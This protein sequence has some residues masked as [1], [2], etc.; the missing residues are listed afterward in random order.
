LVEMMAGFYR[1]VKLGSLT[2]IIDIENPPFSQEKDNFLFGFPLGHNREHLT[3]EN[4]GELVHSIGGY[5]LFLS[6]SNDKIVLANDICGGFRLYHCLI[7]DKIYFSDRYQS[8]VK[9]L[10][11]QK[12][13]ERNDNEYCLWEKQRYTSGERTF[14]KGLNKVAPAS[15]V[16]IDS[17]GMRSSI[18]YK[19]ITTVSSRTLHTRACRDS[20][21]DSLVLLKEERGNKLLFFSGGADSTLLA[22]LMKKLE[23]DF[24]PVF[25]LAEPHYRANYSNYI[26]AE[27][28]SKKNGL[29]LEVFETNL[30][31][32]L[33]NLPEVTDRMLFD[34]HFSLLHFEGA[35]VLA[36]RFGKDS[37]FISGQSADSILSFG[38]SSKAKGDFAARVL[39][40]RPGSIMSRFAAFA[41]RLKHGKRF[42]LSIGNDEFLSA[43]FNPKDYY[44]VTDSE[45]DDSMSQYL[46][47]TI[48]P[49]K[50]R[51]KQSLSLLMYLKSYGF[52]QGSDNQVVFQSALQAGVA[53]VFLPFATPGF[54]YE[55]VK[56][57][58]AFWEIISPK[59]M[60]TDLLKQ[61]GYEQPEYN[62]SIDD[63]DFRRES[64]FIDTINEH[65]KKSSTAIFEQYET[66]LA[67]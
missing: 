23:I 66:E 53:K 50:I 13:L 47:S 57:Q 42:R 52:I 1:E 24:T 62:K 21:I 56:Y 40:R 7:E 37:I 64:L 33:Q 41:V 27:A 3:G 5:F 20:L 39:F 10:A 31:P 22:L 49:I 16:R 2:V 36:E 61:L 12:S 14:I 8:L 28:V 48:E 38:P 43:F 19:D 58:S 30:E 25:L 54:I 46:Q 15:I 18:Y 34:R 9:I 17:G 65:F 45:S 11:T 67:K 6:I 63:H 26:R 4:I 32:G 44:A 29:K 35:K 60:V 55:T 59:Y 51:I